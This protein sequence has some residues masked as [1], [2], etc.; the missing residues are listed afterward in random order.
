MSEPLL[1]KWLDDRRSLTEAEA[2]EL[3]AA[4]TRDPDL[5][6]RVKDQLATDEVLSRR[7]AVDRGS[8]KTQ[9]AQRIANG[10]TGSSFLQSTL[11][12][13]ERTERRRLPWRAW[14][15]EAAVAA[16]LLVGLMGLLLRKPPPTAAPVPASQAASGLNGEYF[17]NRDLKGKPE[18]RRDPVIDF[19]WRGRTGPFPGWGDVFSA[20]WTGS[21]TPEYSERYRFRTMNDDGVR[22]WIDGK[23]VIDDW[24]GRPVVV[25]NR[26]ELQ[27]EA[28]RRV[29]L[30]IEYFNGGDLGVLRL[31][32][33]SP[34]Q[35]E[36]IIPSSH[37]SP[38]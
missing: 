34:S 28:G 36:E 16:L 5:A 13:V 32:W 20:R 9:V 22:V 6:R 27:L 25:E 1:A 38:K 10:A 11:D 26:G 2:L 8:F 31:F 19:T 33:S 37:L 21:L 3:G 14:A 7:L 18:S 4:L 15:P 30:R 12:A 23:L 17:R 35:K 29:D 24:N